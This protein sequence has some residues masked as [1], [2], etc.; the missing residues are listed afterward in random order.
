MISKKNWYQIIR[1]QGESN[2]PIDISIELSQSKLKDEN[3][4]KNSKQHSKLQS[5]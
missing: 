2:I 4:E 3:N 1:A 5:N